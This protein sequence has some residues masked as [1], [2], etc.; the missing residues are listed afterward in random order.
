[1][2]DPSIVPGLLQKH[3]VTAPA[4]NVYRIIEENDI[5]LVFEEM[6]DSDS[7]LLLIEGGRAII[8]IN[9]SH[10]PNRQR[11]TAAHEC[12]HY[13]LHREGDEQLFVDQ[14]FARGPTASAGT[15][16]FEIEANQF[17]AELLMPEDMVK[18]AAVSQSLSDLDIAMLALRFEISEQAMTLRLVK[19]GLVQP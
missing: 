16:A 13:F 12:G 9:D 19:L 3:K 1:M 7:G 17:A 5:R 2:T 8:A 15:D 10:H 14:A 6:D 11:F 18:D 4:V